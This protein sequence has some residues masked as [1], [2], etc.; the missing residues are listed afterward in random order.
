MTPAP[1]EAL[2]KGA[3]SAPALKPQDA[4]HRRDQVDSPDFGSALTVATAASTLAH[5]PTVQAPPRAL[6][7]LPAEGGTP[8]GKVE[9][10]GGPPTATAG[11]TRAA[12]AGQAAHPAAQNSTTGAAGAAGATDEAAEPPAGGPSAQGPTNPPADTVRSGTAVAQGP[13]DRHDPAVVGS[14]VVAGPVLPPA[15]VAVAAQPGDRPA[16]A[17][18]TRSG[19]DA[20]SSTGPARDAGTGPA[21]TAGGEP[22]PAAP[23]AGVA[24]SLPG[25]DTTD[26]VHAGGEKSD[27]GSPAADAATAAPSATAGNAVTSAAGATAPAGEAATTAVATPV[28]GSGGLQPTALHIAPPG[29][30]PASA[31]HAGP[32]GGGSDHGASSGSGA[33]SADQPTVNLAPA[34]IQAPAPSP[35]PV[36]ASGASPGMPAAPAAPAPP[37]TQLVTVLNPLRSTDGI[38]RITMRLQPEGLGLVDATLTVRAGHV[39]IELA[40]D[41]TTGH[42][43]LS[44][45]L[46]D[47]RQ[48]LTEGGRQATV[49]MS[50]GGTDG[51]G[52]EPR[53]AFSRGPG[54]A[55]EPDSTAAFAASSPAPGG[56]VISSS[57]DIRL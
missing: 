10:A 27:G 24:A 36:A 43:A 48:Q 49:F 8:A 44:A 54:S 19:P 39:I 29:G 4:P 12:P 13:G 37:A 5:P 56:P 31:D 33:S 21:S 47:L 26:R 34:A 42:Q 16:V 18:A 14:A 32:A 20:G 17:G 1:V 7:Q 40:A 11:G 28:K 55:A 57:V 52:R 2:L 38:H 41:S 15:V 50:G 23:P 30:H 46:P 9:S 53:A 22:S 6:S 3:A 51:R 35:A 25:A 45:A